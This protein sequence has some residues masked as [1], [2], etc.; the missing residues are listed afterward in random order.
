MSKGISFTGLDVHKKSISVALLKPRARK[1]VEW[2]Q[3][4]DARSVK[5]LIR[6]LKREGGKSIRCCYEAGPCGFGLQRTL[7][8]SGIECQVI[9]PALIPRKPGERIKTDRRDASKLAELFRGGLL[10]VSV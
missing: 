8:S 1:P 3:S 7:Q 6:K 9:A 10:T 5:R 2:Q 4:N